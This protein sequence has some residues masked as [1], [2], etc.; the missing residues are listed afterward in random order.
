MRDW[1]ALMRSYLPDA[2]LSDGLYV[3]GYD[4][5]QLLVHVL[6]QCGEALTRENVVKQATSLNLELPMLLPSILIT[7]SRTDLE[8]IK[9]V[10][11]VRFNG[12]HQASRRSAIEGPARASGVT[13]DGSQ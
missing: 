11:F 8:P 3:T 12:T 7:T 4:A 10:E 13:S 1:R 9:Q 2:D 6:R 5:A